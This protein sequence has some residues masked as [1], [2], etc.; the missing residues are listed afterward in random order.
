MKAG[1]NFS[2][3]SFGFSYLFQNAPNIANLRWQKCPNGSTLRPDLS[4]DHSIL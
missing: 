2:K 1:A 3:Y 4:F